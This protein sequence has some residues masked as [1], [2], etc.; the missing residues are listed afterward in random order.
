LTGY[1]DDINPADMPKIEVADLPLDMIRTR[2]RAKPGCGL[3]GDGPS[4]ISRCPHHADSTPSL[5]V[6][7]SVTP[8]PHLSESASSL[9]R[10]LRHRG[11]VGVAGLSLRHLY[12]TEYAIKMEAKR[13]KAGTKTSD[14]LL[15][16]APYVPPAATEPEIDYDHIKLIFQTHE[17]REN[18]NAVLGHFGASFG[19]GI[20]AMQL[21]GTGADEDANLALAE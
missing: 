6:R 3:R 12:P 4:Y 21:L 18:R 5:S 16:A 8:G 15:P 7:E 17:H 2:L 13:A 14:S 19:V 9:P 10:R 1:G 20:H 11:C